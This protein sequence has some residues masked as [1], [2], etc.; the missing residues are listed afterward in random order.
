MSVVHGG[1]LEKL[2]AEAHCAPGEYWISREPEPCGQPEGCFRSGS[3][4]S[5]MPRRIRNRMR[6]ASAG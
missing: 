2:A 1:N 4:R 6:K 5:I 3:V